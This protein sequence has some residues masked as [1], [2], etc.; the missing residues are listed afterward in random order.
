[1]IQIL[2]T[3]QIIIVLLSLLI[4]YNALSQNNNDIP[5]LAVYHLNDDIKLDGRLDEPIWQK[6]DSIASLTMVEPV[7]N[8]ENEEETVPVPE[9]EPAPK[10]EPAL[11]APEPA[12]PAEQEVQNMLYEGGMYSGSLKNSIPHGQG[13]W[14]RPGGLTYVGEFSEGSATGYGTLTLPSGDRYVGMVLK[15][16]PHGQGKLT[17]VDGTVQEGN[18]VNGTLQ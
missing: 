13:R 12:P 2:K 4:P 10:P 16:I 3:A 8:G 17:K 11:P 1:M 18:W 9:P 15:G 14:S 6:A 7:E 5:V